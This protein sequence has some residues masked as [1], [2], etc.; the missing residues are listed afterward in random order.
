M[1]T[2]LASP[3]ALPLSTRDWGSVTYNLPA[4]SDTF[5]YQPDALRAKELRA[6]RALRGA[7]G[8]EGAEGG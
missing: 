1:K 8:A 6:L 2:F 4:L 7:E 3:P 5:K